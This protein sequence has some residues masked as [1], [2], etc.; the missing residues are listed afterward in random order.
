VWA[1]S[2]SSSVWHQGYGG[3]IWLN[4]FDSFLVSGGIG[5]SEEGSIFTVKAGFLF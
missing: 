3:G 4:I 2:E 5:F 1:D